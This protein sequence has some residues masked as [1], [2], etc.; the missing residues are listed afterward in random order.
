MS[1]NLKIVLGGERGCGKNSLI[2]KILE[3]EL[4]ASSGKSNP[5][6]VSIEY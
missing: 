5:G 2:K 3:R 4:G 6:I 1:T